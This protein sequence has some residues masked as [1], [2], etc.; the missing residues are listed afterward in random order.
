MKWF[1]LWK[2]DCVMSRAQ[3]CQLDYVKT[4]TRLYQQYLWLREC[5][6]NEIVNIGA[7][8]RSVSS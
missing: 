8:S 2:K 4:D 1:C 6:G 7:E 5:P 3:Q